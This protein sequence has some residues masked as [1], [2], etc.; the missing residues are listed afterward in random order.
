MG[1][2]ERPCFLLLNRSFRKHPQDLVLPR[3]RL[4]ESI[5]RSL[6]QLHRHFHKSW[7]EVFL[8]TSSIAVSLSNIRPLISIRMPIIIYYHDC[9]IKSMALRNQYVYTY[10]LAAGGVDLYHDLL[11]I[12]PYRSPQ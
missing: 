12:P 6:L 3:I 11:T 5:I 7:P 8:P 2:Y 1:A 10:K 4:A 9:W